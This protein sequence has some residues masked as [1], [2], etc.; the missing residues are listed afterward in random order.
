MNLFLRSCW[1]RVTTIF[2]YRGW[3]STRWEFSLSVDCSRKIQ[4]LYRQSRHSHQI[5]WFKDDL[6]SVSDV[7]MEGSH[8]DK[9][10]K[11]IWK[12]IFCLRDFPALHMV[13]APPCTLNT[14]LHLCPLAACGNVVKDSQQ[15]QCRG[16][17]NIQESCIPADQ[18]Q[19]QQLVQLGRISYQSFDIWKCAVI[20]W[21]CQVSVVSEYL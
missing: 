19:E 7:F 17:S 5:H 9:L 14:W 3:K 4:K 8:W 21:L 16:S 2:R 15:N 13:T 12:Q 10:L 1:M 18:R 11:N 20:S 6:M